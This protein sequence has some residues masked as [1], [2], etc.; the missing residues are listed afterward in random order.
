MAVFGDEDDTEE[1]DFQDATSDHEGLNGP[2][3]LLASDDEG[4]LDDDFG[5]EG[6]EFGGSEEDNED[7]E[8][9]GSSEEV[10]SDQELEVERQASAIDRKRCAL[11]LKGMC[12]ALLLDPVAPCALG[13]HAHQPLVPPLPSFSQCL[14]SC[15]ARQQREADAEGREMAH[16]DLQTNIQ[17]T[18]ILTLPSGQQLEAERLAPPDLAMVQQ[19]IKDIVRVLESFTQLR[20]PARPRS[21]YISQVSLH[22]APLGP[23]VCGLSIDVALFALHQHHQVAD[24]APTPTAVGLLQLKR[25]LCNYYSYNDFMIDTILNLFSV[26]E[27]LELMEANEVRKLHSQSPCEH[28]LCRSDHKCMHVLQLGHSCTA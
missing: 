13:P 8:N 10:D 5:L 11:Y 3:D 25:D 27:A 16:G 4:S 7:N 2:A 9:A 18:D 22:S 17:E 14:P 19:R 21:D 24:R 28:I 6:D 1:E 20:D 15:R 26:A 23:C 12:S